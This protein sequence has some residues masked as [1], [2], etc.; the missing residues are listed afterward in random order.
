MAAWDIAGCV[1]RKSLCIEHDFLLRLGSVC[2]HCDHNLSDRGLCM[3]LSV[4]FCVMVIEVLK[5]LQFITTTMHIDVVHESI[6]LLTLFRFFNIV[7]SHKQT[8]KFLI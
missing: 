8:S 4:H 2:S 1:I 5:G 7:L 3:N 6:R